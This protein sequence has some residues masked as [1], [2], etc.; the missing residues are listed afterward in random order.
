MKQH[1]KDAEKAMS[2]YN[3]MTSDQGFILD[4]Q[5]MADAEAP[6]MVMDKNGTPLFANKNARS[7][8]E[9]IR[10]GLFPEINKL[11]LRAI[12]TPGGVV[13]LL[14]FEV[15]RGTATLEL[16]ALPMADDR[17]LLL[18]RDV[19]MDRNLRD[20]LIDSR[21]RYRDIVEV[22]SAFAWE[23]DD[24]GNFIFVSPRG[25]LG[26]KADELVGRSPLDFLLDTADQ[27]RDRKSVV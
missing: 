12:T 23:T 1:H 27:D 22:S 2:G 10:D 15:Q 11:V 25:A 3:D 13:E 21:Q 17:V 20:A 9:G 16:T 5:T 6:V 7:F 24:T 19:S 4:P 8:A 26:Y 18:P 14:T